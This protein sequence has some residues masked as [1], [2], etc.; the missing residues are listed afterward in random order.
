MLLKCAQHVVTPKEKRIGLCNDNRV[1]GTPTSATQFGRYKLFFVWHLQIIRVQ[2]KPKRVKTVHVGG[3]VNKPCCNCCGG[4]C[5]GPV[6]CFYSW[7]C[8]FLCCN[9]YR[10]CR[11]SCCG[12]QVYPDRSQHQKEVD[13]YIAG[14]GQ[15]K[16]A[17]IVLLKHAIEAVSILK[18]DWLFQ[19]YRHTQSTVR[20][21]SFDIYKGWGE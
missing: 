20:D 17:E 16:D 12:T 13:F 9:P 14:K 18:N 15:D 19:L 2:C 10:C 1:G 7:C 11:S 21:G 6:A 3:K 8:C 4:C 5:A